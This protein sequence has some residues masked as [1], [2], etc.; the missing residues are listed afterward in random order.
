MNIS[1]KLIKRHLVSGEMVTGKEIAI[2]MEQTLT[3]DV[4]G[5]MAYLGFERLNVPR[6]KTKFSVSY[7]DHNLLQIDYRN[8]DDHKYLQSIAKKYGIYLSRAGNGICHSVHLQRFAVP[9]TSLLGS[10]SHTPT[11]AAAGC[12]AIGAGGLDVAMSMAG[13][14][15]YMN[16]PRVIEVRL[17]GKRKPGVSAK[18]II[19]E[20]LRKISVK[21]GLGAILE[22]TGEGLSDLT[23]SERASIACLGT[24]SGASTSVFP[25]D[26]VTRS[27]LKSQKRQ[28]DWQPLYADPDS[29]YNDLIEI[30]LEDL[31]PLIACPDMPDNVVAVKDLPKTKVDQV[32]V[33]SCANASY[34][35]L[36]KVATILEGRV[37]H[38]D[39]SLAIAVGTRQDLEL[40]VRDG[41]MEKLIQAGARIQECGCGACVGIGQAPNTGG[42]S[43]RTSPRNF[44]G[45]SGTL[46][47]R[48]YLS[49]P[50]VAAATALTGYICDPRSLGMDLE[51]V[52]SITDP[53]EYIADDSL[54]IAPEKDSSRV[55]IYRGPNIKPMPVNEA[56]SDK[57]EAPVI[58]YL[59]D[60][61]TTDD[62]L[63]AGA[64]FSA[65][66]SN[67]PEISKIVFGRID[68]DFQARIAQSKTGI[69]VGGENYGQGSSREHAALA[70]MYLG[71]K[72]VVAKSIARIHKANLVNYG[73]LPLIFEDKSDHKGIEQG[74][75]LL[76]ENAQEQV[77]S[78]TVTIRNI[79]KG[80]QI[81][82]SLEL[83]DRD[84]EMILAG[85]KLNYVRDRMS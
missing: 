22:Y 20:V 47:A 34:A 2:R 38:P 54:V 75:V 65:L 42:V 64:S 17:S 85:G 76:I 45:R 63:P 78:R 59:D 30:D 23:V 27:F 35:D 8:M 29:R 3:H 70:P 15:F 77:K 81:R 14:P 1:E 6:V 16:M 7:V 60:N 24:E 40:L 4:T 61:V 28:K 18:D 37:I 73:I 12:L 71:I 25:S 21:G 46:D 79:T 36:A 32:F 58:I 83:S 62:I 9:G 57:L 56:L 68:P 72:A 53:M 49:G 26:E 82:T 55:E 69:I 48:V 84:L 39:V 11:N 33:G 43:V 66:R 50:E 13:E 80:T 52:A 51:K 41:Y 10:D 67:V 5:T 19:L 44:R 74:D 31:R